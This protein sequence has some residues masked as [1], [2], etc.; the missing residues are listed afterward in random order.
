MQHYAVCRCTMDRYSP[1][2]AFHAHQKTLGMALWSPSLAAPAYMVVEVQRLVR[3]RQ[4]Q[5][6]DVCL[7]TGW[8]SVSICREQETLWAALAARHASSCQASAWPEPP[9]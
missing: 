1:L 2:L 6:Q 5:G 7:L 3:H 8:A 9:S 4:D